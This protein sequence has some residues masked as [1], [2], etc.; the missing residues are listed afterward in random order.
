MRSGP[1]LW[2]YL[3]LLILSGILPCSPKCVYGIQGQLH[4]WITDHL[5][6]HRRHV[7]LNGTLSFPLPVKAGVPQDSVLGPILFLIFINDRT[8]SLENHLYPFDD[9]T[10]CRDIAHPSDRQ[11]AASSFSLDL[12]KIRNWSNTIFYP[13][14][15]PFAFSL[16]PHRYL[17]PLFVHLRPLS[18][19]VLLLLFPL[20]LA[21]PF[22]MLCPDLCCAIVLP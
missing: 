6:S 8:V 13:Y 4:S 16:T 21:V 10:R 7:A 18:P 20:S 14:C 15:P 2:T 22:I 9:S 3:K 1:S 11:A 17:R 12:D 19:S 5:P